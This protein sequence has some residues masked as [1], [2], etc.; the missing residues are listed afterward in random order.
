MENG[1]TILRVRQVIRSVISCLLIAVSLALII[2]IL[3]LW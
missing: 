3:A 2:L 1:T